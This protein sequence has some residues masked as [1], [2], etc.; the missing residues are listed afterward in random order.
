M[1]TPTY[2]SIE[3]TSLGICHQAVP[4]IPGSVPV[5]IEHSVL[6]HES[7]KF[8]VNAEALLVCVPAIN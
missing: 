5:Q 1:Q 4:N 8:Q 7:K 6:Q 3:L 2:L